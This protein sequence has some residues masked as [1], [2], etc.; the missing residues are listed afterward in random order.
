[1]MDISGNSGVVSIALEI[2]E[3]RRDTLRQMKAALEKGEHDKVI[4]HAKELCGIEDE[5]TCDR[6]DTSIN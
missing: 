5:Q 3:R 4:E 1:M 6:I 2:S